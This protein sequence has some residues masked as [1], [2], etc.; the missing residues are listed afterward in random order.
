MISIPLALFLALTN[1]PVAPTALIT[2][3]IAEF[4]PDDV[5]IA[6]VEYV[7]CGGENAFYTNGRTSIWLPD[8][9]HTFEARELIVC[10]EVLGLPRGVLRTLVAHELSHA[11]IDQYRIPYVG[12]EEAAA[13]ELATVMLGTSGDVAALMEM[14]HFFASLP[15]GG[16]PRDS[17]PYNAQRA[18]TFACAADGASPDPVD[19]SCRTEFRRAVRSWHRLVALYRAADS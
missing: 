18:W 5:E 12:S 19:W 9:P 6:R 1:P 8:G 13:D 7:D 15:P 17:H 16:N 10:T 2:D 3:T 14:A 4:K 11:V